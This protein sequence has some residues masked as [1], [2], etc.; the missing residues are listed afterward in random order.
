MILNSRRD[1]QRAK[2]RRGAALPLVAVLLPVLMGFAALS[3]DVGYLHVVKAQLQNAAD[4]ASLAGAS[5]YYSDA[6]LKQALEE[7]DPLVRARAKMVASRNPVTG[8]EVMLEE[9]YILLGQ[10]DVNN[11]T[12]PLLS[13]TPWNAVDVTARRTSDSPNGPVGLFFAAIF[14]I[15]TADVVA[16]AR[17]VGSDHMSGYR[18]QKDF[19]LI[20]F[21]IHEDRYTELCAN[22][23]DDYSYTSSAVAG[24]D[25]VHEIRLYPWRSTELPQADEGMV[26]G[27][28]NFGTLTVG[29]G[30]QGTTFLENQIQ[31]G[32][33]A[34]ELQTQFGTSTLVFY[35][36]EHTP[37]TGPRTYDAP[38][39]PGLSAGFKDSLLARKGEIVG[40]F[41]HRGVV[42]DGSNAIFSIC[43]VAFGRVMDVR[44]SGNPKERAVV[45]QPIPWSDEW[46]AILAS[47]PSTNGKMGRVV[48]VQ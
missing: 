46:V 44:L 27:S 6:G 48:L 37:E 11:R 19:A 21:T 8:K 33:S 2:L 31:E 42:S 7:L 3:V 22:G 12:G 30:S 41:L 14:G 26:D 17:A 20:P 35:D 16:H 15:H 25:G 4:A 1:P 29:L 24:G 45:I 38:G 34:T 47:A 23:P 10:H 18:L 36:E 5:A 28:G 39:N 43:G 40:F 13:N 32:I 9:Q